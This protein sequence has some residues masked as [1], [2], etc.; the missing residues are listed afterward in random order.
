MN[1]ALTGSS[2]FIGAH[3]KQKLL[4]EHHSLICLTRKP[5]NDCDMAIDLLSEQ[6]NNE[7]IAT[8]KEKKIDT[9]IHLA[10]CFI[11]SPMNFQQE[12]EVFDKNIK[13]IENI[14]KIASETNIRKILFFSSIAVYPNKDGYYSE[15]SEINMSTNCECMYGL[16]KFCSEMMLLHYLPQTIV[17]I[18]RIAQVYGEGMRSDRIIEVLKQELFENNTMHVWG[19]GKRI[20]NFIRVDKLLEYLNKFIMGD[21]PGIYNVGDVNISYLE[22]AK[23]LKDKY[24]NEDT[25][26]ILDSRGVDAKVFINIEKLNETIK[27]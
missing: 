7:Q 13:M 1:I 21:Y 12:K 26:I 6:I 19:N 11:S 27:V 16:S 22:L 20:S 10:S 5:K 9:L 2:G 8:L 24:G 17:S 4:E 3:L 23:R 25:Q 15:E 18:L 14:I